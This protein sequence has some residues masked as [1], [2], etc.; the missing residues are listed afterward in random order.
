MKSQLNPDVWDAY[1]DSYWDKQLCFLIRYGFPLDFDHNTLLKSNHR[2]HTSAVDF[3]DDIQAYLQEEI[4]H[5]AIYGPFQ[6]PPLTNLHCSPL[7]TREKPNAPI[8]ASLS[9]SAFQRITLST[10]AYIMTHI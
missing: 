8:D 1:L 4:S 7:M 6:S 10:Q 9:T 3:P 5:E 2:N